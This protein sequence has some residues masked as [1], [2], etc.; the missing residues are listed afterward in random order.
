MKKSIGRAVKYL[1]EQGNPT[2]PI[3]VDVGTFTDIK[4][5]AG[6][7]GIREYDLVYIHSDGLV[8]NYFE[9]PDKN[10]GEIDLIGHAM[11][12]FGKDLEEACGEDAVFK[13]MEKEQSSKSL[14]GIPDGATVYPGGVWSKGDDLK[15][16]ECHCP[17]VNLNH[18]EDCEY[19]KNKAGL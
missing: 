13:E 18:D 3:L 12:E 7:V 9:D 8:Y 16:G 17:F 1:P 6:M 19:V 11:E 4:Y 14:P 10:A 5:F 2:L 15:D